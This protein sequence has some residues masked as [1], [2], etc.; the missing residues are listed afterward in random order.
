[1]TPP[2]EIDGDR[3]VETLRCDCGRLL[4]RVLRDA[5]ELKCGRCKRVVILVGGRRFHEA[6][7]GGCRCLEEYVP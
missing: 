6:G 7:G 3:R 4:A 5:V 1:M 2:G